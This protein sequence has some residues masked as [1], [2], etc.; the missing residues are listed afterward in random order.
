MRG[1]ETDDANG[2]LKPLQMN[3]CAAHENAWEDRLQAMSCFPGTSGCWILLNAVAA[4]S[5]TKYAAE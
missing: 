3:C 2:Q 4:R 1:R 5:H